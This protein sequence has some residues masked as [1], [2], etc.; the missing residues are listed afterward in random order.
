MLPAS[1]SD[2][3]ITLLVI[4]I[5]VLSVFSTSIAIFSKNGPGLYTYQSIRGQQVK[6]YGIGVYKHMS[7]E[8][9]PQGI[10]QDYVTLLIA[11]PLLLLSYRRTKNSA[12]ARFVFTGT[13]G[14]F[15]VTYF[16]YLCMAM[17]NALFLAYVA[18]AGCSFFAF[19]ISLEKTRQALA[20]CRFGIRTP[21]RAAGVFLIFN[22][23]MIALLWLSIVIPPLLN[24]SIVPVQAEHYTTLIVQGVDLAILLPGAFLSGMWLLKQEPRGL[25]IAPVYLIFLSL[26]MV[27]LV[28]KIIAM[29]VLGYNIVPVVFIIPCFAITSIAFSVVLMKNLQIN[30]IEPVRKEGSLVG[31]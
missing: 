30:I 12:V 26:L 27:A 5:A 29:G 11:L 13:L 8:V 6:I 20:H 10:A 1:K 28:A 21:F 4:V 19:L 23:C 18:L 14:Y 31:Q 3:S 17:Y 2:R 25:L 9:A 7:A 16:F 15:L 22:A 24:G